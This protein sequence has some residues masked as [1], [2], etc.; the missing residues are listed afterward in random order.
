MNIGGS[1]GFAPGV[2]AFHNNLL[3]HEKSIKFSSHFASLDNNYTTLAYY[4]KSLLGSSL[5]FNVE[6][7]FFSN[8]EE[9][10]F[11]RGNQGSETNKTI[12][13]VEEGKVHVGLGYKLNRAI[14]WHCSGILKHIDISQA[15]E[16]DETKIPPDIPGFGTTK[17]WGIGTGIAFDFRNGWPR[18]LSG[19]S[20]KLDYRRSREMSDNRFEFHSYAVEAQQFIPCHF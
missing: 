14:N 15:S 11:I 9:N 12:Y 8:T 17:L 16:E 10:H 3:G 6:T 19:A 13:D 1:L 5:Q 7:H 20:I 18:T 2:M 4:D